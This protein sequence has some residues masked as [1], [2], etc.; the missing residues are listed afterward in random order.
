MKWECMHG[1]KSF[2]I[3]GKWVVNSISRTTSHRVPRF[4]GMKENTC[5]GGK[6]MTKCLFSCGWT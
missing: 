1:F 3:F 2:I 4:Y 6:K 5:V